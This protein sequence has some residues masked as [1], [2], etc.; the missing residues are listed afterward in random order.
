MSFI[1]RCAAGA[2]RSRAP[3][4]SD[5]RRHGMRT[6]ESLFY[7]A[8]SAAPSLALWVLGGT[9]TRGPNGWRELPATAFSVGLARLVLIVTVVVIYAIRLPFLSS[10]PGASLFIAP[11]FTYLLT[12]LTFSRREG[13]VPARLGCSPGQSHR[14]VPSSPA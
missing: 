11:V 10:R 12:A 3:V 2:S 5:A 1:I 14:R 13:L 4:S 8:C 9:W 7:P 6:A